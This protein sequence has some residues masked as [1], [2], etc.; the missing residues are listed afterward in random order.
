MSGVLNVLEELRP[1][2]K[3]PPAHLHK[4]DQGSINNGQRACRVL[5]LR[6]SRDVQLQDTAEYSSFKTL[7]ST[8]ASRHSRVLQL[9]DTAEYS[10]FKTLHSTPASRHCRVLQLQD[11]AEYSPHLELN[12]G[13]ES[14]LGTE[15][16]SR[17]A[18]DQ[19][20]TQSKGWPR[21]WSARTIYIR[22]I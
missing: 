11:T 6:H 8:P 2:T 16:P 13:K 7:Q 18:F 5:S 3:C 1:R 4:E 14:Y 17:P 20:Y 22:F 9:Q 12:L 15:A 21:T 19:P 10:S